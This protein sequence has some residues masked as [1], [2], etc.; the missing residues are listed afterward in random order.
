MSYVYNCAT[1]EVSY[2]KEKFNLTRNLLRV[3]LTG[4]RDEKAGDL[5]F[6]KRDWHTNIFEKARVYE[7]DY[8]YI[9]FEEDFF[10][11]SNLIYTTG[12]MFVN[13]PNGETCK[14]ALQ[15]LLRIKKDKK[16][17]FLT[18]AD[19]GSRS[20]IGSIYYALRELKLLDT[21]RASGNNSFYID[22]WNSTSDN[23]YTRATHKL[24][25]FDY[26]GQWDYIICP[27]MKRETQGTLIEKLLAECNT[28]FVLF[29][30]YDK[31]KD[32]KYTR[33]VK[34]NKGMF[35][36]VSKTKEKQS[37][38]EIKGCKMHTNQLTDFLKKDI[39]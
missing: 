16:P 1:R 13:L 33:R 32:I 22:N 21:R 18:V 8:E 12:N 29:G 15:K 38:Y 9:V 4:L 17:T 39:K 14:K 5:L 35:V 23:V 7:K 27:A 2:S 20:T 30:S 37:E 34:V 24:N 10:L 19:D 11:Q 36:Y 25:Y 3:L 6:L 28:G 31:L 26:F